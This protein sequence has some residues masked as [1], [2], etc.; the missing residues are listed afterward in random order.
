MRDKPVE[1]KKCWSDIGVWGDFTCPQLIDDIH[2][3]NCSVYGQAGQ[4]LLER[5]DLDGYTAEWTALMA[6]PRDPFQTKT[7]QDRLSVTVFRLGQ[8]WLA[9]PASIFHQVVSPNPVHSLPHRRDPL[10]RGIVNVRGQLLP[11]VSLHELL[12]IAAPTPDAPASLALTSAPAAI[13]AITHLKS[14]QPT[15]S[16]QQDNSTPSQNSSIKN[17]ST[18]NSPTQ[19]SPTKSTQ[20]G[21]YP[22]LV[23][24]KQLREIW[25]FE[26][27]E[28]YGMHRCQQEKMRE[29]PAFSNK[30]L[31]NFTQSI[32]PWN[33]QNVSYLDAEQLFSALRQR[34][35]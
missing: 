1:I 18:K 23:V 35:L 13:G 11:C 31:A 19:N 24:I 26:V 22:R 6:L 21:G 20:Q 5:P 32:F 14:T 16:A 2:C 30:S 29:A 4:D 12:S 33:D 28:I 34:A 8:E 3:H 9:L 25:A 15:D 10:L 27:N 17:S 7:R